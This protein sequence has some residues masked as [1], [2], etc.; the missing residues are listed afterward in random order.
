MLGTYKG[1]DFV[2]GTA[3]VG[4]NERPMSKAE[5]RAKG[6][7]ENS[8][9]LATRWWIDAKSPSGQTVRLDDTCQDPLFKKD[10][11]ERMRKLASQ[12]NL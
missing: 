7:P 8:V 4:D 12:F 1:Q 2:T 3:V 11:A 5:C 9:H 10:G 6:L